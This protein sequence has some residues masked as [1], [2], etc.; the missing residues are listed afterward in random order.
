MNYGLN[1][2]IA[3][4][5]VLAG[6]AHCNHAVLRA[7]MRMTAH[8]TYILLA[9]AANSSLWWHTERWLYQQRR[10]LLNPKSFVVLSQSTRY[11]AAHAS[12]VRLCERVCAPTTH[13]VFL[14][15]AAVLFRPGVEQWMR[16]HSRSVTEPTL[17]ASSC[18][19]WWRDGA[20]WPLQTLRVMF[21][22]L[23][24]E[25]AG[26]SMSTQC[27]D[28]PSLPLRVL[29]FGDADSMNDTG[30]T[31]DFVTRLRA[32]AA[33]D[34]EP[35]RLAVAILSPQML[36][37]F[38]AIMQELW[39]LARRRFNHT[40]SSHGHESTPA[41]ATGARFKAVLLP[42]PALP[43]RP[44]AACLSGRIR[45]LRL[46]RHSIL[47]TMIKPIRPSVDFFA[48][49]SPVLD[50]IPAHYAKRMRISLPK[51]GPAASEQA[52]SEQ[53]RTWLNDFEPVAMRVARSADQNEG[54]HACLSLIT[55]HETQRAASYTWVL[56]LRPDVAYGAQLPPWPSW[57]TLPAAGRLVI[58]TDA[59]TSMAAPQQRKASALGTH[60]SYARGGAC[61]KDVWA[62]V[63][64]AA[65][66]AYFSRHWPRPCLPD[67]MPSYPEC[68]LGCAMH[69]AQVKVGA[70]DVRRQIIR[71]SL[72]SGANVTLI[73]A[74]KPL[75]LQWTQV[76][77]CGENNSKCI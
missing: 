19:S 36:S 74:T 76:Q 34:D 28:S 45:T 62:L 54:L 8:T 7:T 13:M 49:V 67:S 24:T 1:E 12:N 65:A 43:V 48:A 26:D 47:Q 51:S 4:S 61:V 53:I 32:L 59:S 72:G 68:K 46:T 60:R 30:H 58:S 3:V 73:A 42:P 20:H 57:G 38:A 6:S 64:R 29:H 35:G 5:L 40:P 17:P 22:H 15:D 70:I 23:T 55:E 33:A 69:Q 14:S 37:S 56:R 50:D 25:S 10:A 31:A 41:V 18:A 44:V 21:S 75:L 27:P 71:P 77:I 16:Q 39:V 52:S 11:L 9:L 66:E 63:S 2:S